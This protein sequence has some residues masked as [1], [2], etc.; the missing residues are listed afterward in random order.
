MALTLPA[1]GR[2]E[3]IEHRAIMKPSI[4]AGLRILFSALLFA[5]LVWW[6]QLDSILVAMRSAEPLFLGAAL[7]LLPLNLGSSVLMWWLLLR[8]IDPNTTL[9]SAVAAVFAGYSLALFTPARLGDAGARIY[10]H[11]RRAGRGSSHS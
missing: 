9:R 10:Y 8:A 5:F 11:R 1:P 3:S 2:G 7:L 6:I 4:K